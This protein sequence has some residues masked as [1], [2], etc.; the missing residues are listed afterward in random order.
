MLFA[1]NSSLMNRTLQRKQEYQ[2]NGQPRAKPE[3]SP[4]LHRPASASPASTPASQAAPASSS[5]RVAKSPSDDARS[6]DDA[7][8]KPTNSSAYGGS[9][10]TGQ[11]PY[12]QLNFVL[13]SV[14]DSNVAASATR[15]TQLLDAD[16]AD[17]ICER[18]VEQLVTNAFAQSLYGKPYVRMLKILMAEEV[19]TQTCNLW[20]A[21]RARCTTDVTRISETQTANKFDTKG[22]GAFHAHLYLVGA[23]NDSQVIDFLERLSAIVLLASAAQT[24]REVCC[25]IIITTLQTLSVEYVSANKAIPK[26]V[27]SFVA[28]HLEPMWRD[29]SAVPMRIRIRLLDIK[30]TF[31]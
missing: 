29:D 14:V 15:I 1:P 20:I 31:A 25:E 16:D 18:M 11:D 22:M 6:S 9:G 3:I 13:N 21:V 26:S 8:R 4:L 7:W 19:V 28:R 17:G 5:W 2:R 27:R 23:L 24:A 12:K 30:E 10:S